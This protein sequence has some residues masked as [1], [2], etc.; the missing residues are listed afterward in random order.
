[1]GASFASS[2]LWGAMLE[3]N[4]N[5]LKNEVNEKVLKAIKSN[6]KHD[7]ENA[8]FLIFLLRT[9]TLAKCEFSE[10]LSLSLSEYCMQNFENVF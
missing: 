4:L 6:C 10:R 5:N 3:Q 7:R 9:M 2:F 1:M 8:K